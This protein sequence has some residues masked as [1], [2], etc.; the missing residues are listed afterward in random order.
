MS[1]FSSFILKNKKTLGGIL[2]LLFVVAVL[3]HEVKHAVNDHT[4]EME[5]LTEFE[6]IY[7]NQPFPTLIF[8]E[9][10]IPDGAGQQ[11]LIVG[12]GKSG[13]KEIIQELEK[14]HGSFN[15]KSIRIRGTLYSS[16]NKTIV[17]LSQGVDALLAIERSLTYPIQRTAKTPLELTGEIVNAKCWY[18]QQESR[19]GY[20]HQRCSK[21]CIKNGIPPLLKVEK[22]SGNALYILDATTEKAKAALIDGVAEQ[23]TISGEVNFQNGWSVLSFAEENITLS[24]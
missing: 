4:Y 10:F 16:D 17:E 1:L 24:N 22:P 15:G 18:S 14:K 11:A 6:G 19:E 12:P 5:N 8:D 20:Y 13:A 7:F 21:A 9:Y 3:I 2:F 23:I